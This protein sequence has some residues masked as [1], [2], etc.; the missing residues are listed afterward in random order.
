MSTRTFTLNFLVASSMLPLPQ[1]RYF[2]VLSA[3]AADAL[4]I[5]ARRRDG[6]PV[7][8]AGVGAGLQ[9]SAQEGLGW[10][11]L[12]V[13]S[14]VAQEVKIVI[15]DEGSVS[16]ASAV[17]VV[18]SPAVS[19]LPSTVVQVSSAGLLANAQAILSPIA[20][21]KRLKIKARSTNTAPLYVGGTVGTTDGWMLQPGEEIT[22]DTRATVNIVNPGATNPAFS[23]IRES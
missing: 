4:T 1:G 21:Q 6:Q 13:E 14:A 22:L 2:M 16:V 19:V 15:S 7:E 12:E 23:W 8:F 11:V 20:N 9:Y 17:S 18:N 3:P 10:Y 5:R